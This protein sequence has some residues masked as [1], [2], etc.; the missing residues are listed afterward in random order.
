MGAW[1]AIYHLRA[2]TEEK[3][4]KKDPEYARYVK[5]VKWRYIP[6]VY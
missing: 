6:E 5:K 1:S 2:I 4:L 3:H